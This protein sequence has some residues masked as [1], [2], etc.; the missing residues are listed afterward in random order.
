VRHYRKEL[1]PMSIARALFPLACLVV[2][3]GC[4]PP[5]SGTST[6]ADAA[7]TSP[8]ASNCDAP[9][10]PLALGGE[11]SGAIPAA[12]NYPDNARYYCIN[13]GQGVSSVTMELSGMSVDLDLYVG[14]GNI[15][16]VQGVDISAGENYE[17][18][19][20]EFGTGAERITINTPQPGV[21]YAE[22]VSYQG[23][24]SNYTFSAR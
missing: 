20:N 11:V 16:S 1:P 12:A 18:K 22:I 9:A 2:F 7:A 23:E 6:G 17:W 4:T 15:A 24:A 5:T 21:Y 3:A 13:V 19:S 10:V 14:S 8:L